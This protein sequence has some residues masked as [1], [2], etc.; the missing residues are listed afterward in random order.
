MLEKLLALLRRPHYQSEATELIAQLRRSRPQ[1]EERQ[2]AGRALLW[3]KDIDRD[4]VAGNRAAKVP[5]KAYV[6]QTN[7]VKQPGT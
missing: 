4:L 7:V 2:R 6:Y 3:D 1:L 5:Q